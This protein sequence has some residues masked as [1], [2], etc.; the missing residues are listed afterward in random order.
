MPQSDIVS[1]I[2][3]TNLPPRIN[4]P[5]PPSPSV[6]S[7]PITPAV[8][9]DVQI[10]AFPAHGFNFDTQLQ[11]N[12]VIMD[13]IPP[14]P[15][16]ERSTFSIAEALEENVAADP[17]LADNNRNSIGLGVTSSE[18]DESSIARQR[19]MSYSERK[20]SLPP[21]QV[22][23]TRQTA[24]LPEPRGRS[25]SARVNSTIMEGSRM[26]MSMAATNLRPISSINQSPTRRKLRRSWMPG[27]SRSNSIDA[28][29]A[30][31]MAAWV[32]SDGSKA[33]YNTAFLV[34]GD[35]VK[36]AIL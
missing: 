17:D 25:V 35:K 32:M 34:N 29:H 13:P 20:D 10:P 24:P 28:N 30:N 3:N 26:S 15:V 9:Y 23:K 36:S 12:P 18:S 4:D 21:M 19:S 14:S 27:R 7:A 33:E 31:K 2:D 16:P 1:P 6:Y 8:D 11:A 22:L 5:I